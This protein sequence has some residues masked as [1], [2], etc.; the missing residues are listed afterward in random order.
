MGRRDRA[1][2]LHTMR[3]GKTLRTRNPPDSRLYH[4]SSNIARQIQRSTSNLPPQT[5]LVYLRRAWMARIRRLTALDR[6]DQ[7]YHRYPD[8][9]RKGMPRKN[10]CPLHIYRPSLMISWEEYTEVMDHYRGCGIFGLR[11]I[12]P[13]IIPR[14]GRRRSRRYLRNPMQDRERPPANGRG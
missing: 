6:S 1:K 11:G 8:P 13:A 7:L 3:H 9:A 12:W 4:H 14:S 2:L 5:I 10:G